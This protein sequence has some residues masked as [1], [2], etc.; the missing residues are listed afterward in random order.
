M[1]YSKFRFTIQVMLLFVLESS[2]FLVHGQDTACPNTLYT[3]NREY[4][5]NNFYNTTEELYRGRNEIIINYLNITNFD[6]NSFENLT[7]L[8]SLDIGQNNMTC[9]LDEKIFKSLTNL[10]K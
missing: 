2:L 6:S 3:W 8:T 9:L 4:I 10:E 7:Y 1:F 5:V